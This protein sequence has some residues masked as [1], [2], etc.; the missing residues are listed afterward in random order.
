[1][2]AIKQLDILGYRHKPVPHTFFQQE[3]AQHVAIVLP[4]MGYTSHM[5]LLYYPASIMLDLGADVLRLEYEYTRQEDFMVLKGAERKQWLLSDVTNACQT[6]LGERSYEKITLM[7]KS[8]GTRA[9]GHL[10][11]TEAEFN[12][13]AAIWLTP[14]IRSEGLR[15]QIKKWGKRSLFVIGTADQH[16]DP[17]LI[18]EIRE[19]TKGEVLVI[20]GADHSLEIQGNLLQSLQAM[21]RVIR[22]I[23]SF[24]AS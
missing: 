13:A 14:V 22:T 18:E 23:Q 17:H 24:V 2:Y 8:I 20:E 9:M 19:A 15:A 7:G 3:E 5:P 10:L 21:E 12:Q 6:V 11:T 16:Y 4:G 1:M